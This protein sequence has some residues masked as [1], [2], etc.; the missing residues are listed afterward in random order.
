MYLCKL[1]VS[2]TLKKF[3]HKDNKIKSIMYLCSGIVC[4]FCGS[5]DFEQN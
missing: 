3:T 5:S 4:K 2:L 1:K